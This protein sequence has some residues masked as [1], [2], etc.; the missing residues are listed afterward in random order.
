MHAVALRTFRIAAFAVCAS[1][2]LTACKKHEQQHAAA[3]QA[4]AT[5]PSPPTPIQEKKQ[6][7][8]GTTWDPQWDQIV[9]QAV[10]PEMLSARV[11]RDIRRFCP[12]FYEMAEE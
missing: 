10:P 7:L 5:K 2:A 9:E 8:G 3:P 11:P 6:E 4:P 1:V 12:R